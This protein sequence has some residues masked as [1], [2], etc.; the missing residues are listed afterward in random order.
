M[1]NCAVGN[2]AVIETVLGVTVLQV[3]ALCLT[4]LCVTALSLRYRRVQ[5]AL[6]QQSSELQDTRMLTEFLERVELEESQ[7]QQGHRYGDLAQ[8]S[9]APEPHPQHSLSPLQHSM[10]GFKEGLFH[11]VCSNTAWPTGALLS[12]V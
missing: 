7:A 10:A 5:S 9:S 2:C 8:V 3:T 11:Y 4:V 12:R 1:C 6:T